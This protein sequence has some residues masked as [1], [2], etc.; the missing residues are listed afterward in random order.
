MQSTSSKWSLKFSTVT[1]MKTIEQKLDQLEDDGHIL[2]EG[3]LS[4]EK[5]N[6]FGNASITPAK[7]V[8]LTG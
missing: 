6:T 7:W 5:P 8:G 1:I 2:V 4:P 3:A